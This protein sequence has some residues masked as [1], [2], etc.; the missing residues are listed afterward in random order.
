M[1]KIRENI[2]WSINNII[3]EFPDYSSLA[4]ELQITNTLAGSLLAMGELNSDFLDLLSYFCFICTKEQ[5]NKSNNA[6]VQANGNH[7]SLD[8]YF[9]PLLAPIAEIIGSCYEYGD[10]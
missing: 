3:V 6:A 2:L 8:N 5:N 7:R 9:E 1:N 4:L 10:D